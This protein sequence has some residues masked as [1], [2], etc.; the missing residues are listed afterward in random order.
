MICLRVEG[1]HVLVTG[2]SSGLGR[3]F[4]DFLAERGARVTVAAR[5][6]EAFAKTVDDIAAAKGQ[7][8]SVVMDVTG[9]RKHR[10]GARRRRSEVR[11]G[12]RLSSTMP[13]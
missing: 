12:S 9:R 13:G 8:Q 3:S 1:K 11:P 7:A 5:R 4:A 10:G 2:G 6:A